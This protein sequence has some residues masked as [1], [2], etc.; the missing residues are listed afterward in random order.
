MKKVYRT[1]LVLCTV[2]LLTGVAFGYVEYQTNST[3]DNVN[4]TNNSVST[5]KNNVSTTNVTGGKTPTVTSAPTVKNTNTAVVPTETAVKTTTA[6]PTDVKS[7]IPKET[8][9]ETPGFGIVAAIGGI[10][11]VVYMFGKRR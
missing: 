9:K 2:A 10:L 8:P 6:K 4:T 1:M 3:G 5:A 7:T 11:S